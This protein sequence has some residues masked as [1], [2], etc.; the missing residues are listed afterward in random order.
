VKLA[1]GVG[2]RPRPGRDYPPATIAR[3]VLRAIGKSGFQHGSPRHL[4]GGE[5]MTVMALVVCEPRA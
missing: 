4:V 1:E 2:A 5:M 3:R